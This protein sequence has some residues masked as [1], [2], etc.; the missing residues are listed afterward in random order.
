VYVSPDRRIAF[1]HRR[2]AIIDLTAGQQPM[3]NEDRTIWVGFNG[4]IYNHRDLRRQLEDAG[5]R[6]RTTS[7]TET[8]LHAYEEY[9]EDFVT[10][11][12]GEFALVL[13]DE[14]RGVGL[15]ARDRL[16]IRPLYYA[17]HR[18]RLYFASEITALKGIP[19]FAP[20]IDP[21][22]LDE[23]LSL[24][25]SS[26][27]QST[28]TGVRR[29]LPGAT[30]RLDIAGAEPRRFWQIPEEQRP[31]SIAEAAEQLDS[32]LSESVRLR[33]MSDVPI[34]MYLSGGIDSGVILALMARERGQRVRTFSI[35]FGL[36]L[37]ETDS[38]AELARRFDAEHTEVR[39]PT[40][41]F[42]ALP[43]VVGKLDEPLGDIIILPT[44]YLSRAAA[45][46]VKVVLTGEGADELFG[47]YVHQQALA[48]YGQYRRWCPRPLRD[49]PPAVLERLPLR[50]LDR[51]FPYPESLGEAGR[52]R[53]TTFLRE[54]ETGRAYLTLV[55]L[56]DRRQ[57]EALLAPQWRVSA[58]WEA[59]YATSDWSAARFRES[60]IALDC[61]HWLPDYTLFKQDRLTMANSIE[62]RVPFLD[63]RLVEFVLSLPS[64]YKARRGTQKYLLR[65]VARRYLGATRARVPKAAFYL[66]VRKFFAA[67][68]D[69][70]VRDTLS[71]ASV[72]RDG[73]FEPAAVNQLV[74]R[75]LTDS[76]LD[77]KRLI[78]VLTFT[79]WARAQRR[80]QI[81]NVMVDGWMDGRPQ[82]IQ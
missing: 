62:G 46:H 11:L 55:E 20:D 58:N 44:Y 50:I 8:L 37:D 5:H 3:A 68:F 12:N 10:R 48:R 43:D 27:E 64:S 42:E 53:V 63:H 21:F 40:R 67:D 82:A 41:A 39:L 71:T 23:F 80:T 65:H 1:A 16:G 28:L 76:L 25:Y 60:A 49:V 56:F 72:R 4:E 66:P 6:Y 34:G 18:G 77:G 32:L 24:R 75:G 57:K 52:Q 36:P 69:G 17:E 30:L 14:R 33:L 45:S 54:A 19:G 38:A 2:L 51:L 78:A 59:T 7:D 61:R 13:Y 79:L 47:S 81:G 9:G 22:A 31:C 74:E 29:L 73:F 35:G 15:L 70:F 26:G